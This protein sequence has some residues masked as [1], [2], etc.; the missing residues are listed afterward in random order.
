MLDV[1]ICLMPAAL[2]RWLIIR[3]PMGRK[4]AIWAAIAIGIGS[5]LVFYAMNLD[6]SLINRLATMSGVGSYFVLRT[7]ARRLGH[8]DSANVKTSPPVTDDVKELP[9]SSIEEPNAFYLYLDQGVKGPFSREQLKAL[10]E[11]KTISTTTMFCPEGSETWSELS[12]YVS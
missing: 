9:E 6:T 3:K 12:I 1:L 4:S 8:V 11:L 2:W 5:I 7:G 10:L